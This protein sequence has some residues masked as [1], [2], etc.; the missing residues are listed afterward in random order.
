MLALSI[1]CCA[2]T[3]PSQTKIRNAC[4]NAASANPGVS[5]TSIAN[6][7]DCIATSAKK[8]LDKDD[9]VLLAKVSSVY[10]S[11]ADDEAK[12]HG[13]ANELVDSGVTPARA[14]IAAMDFI[15]LAHKV[16]GECRR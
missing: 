7:C 12:L 2:C 11:N 3:D 5:S 13:I 9:Y 8:Y 4:I 6:E 14:S 10:M 15:F 16:D 1:L